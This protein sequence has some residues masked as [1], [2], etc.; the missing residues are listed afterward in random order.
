MYY[1]VI[2]VLYDMKVGVLMFVVAKISVKSMEY[3]T[4][5]TLILVIGLGMEYCNRISWLAS[6]KFQ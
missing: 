3:D 4:I 1:L 5:V 2:N 6:Q